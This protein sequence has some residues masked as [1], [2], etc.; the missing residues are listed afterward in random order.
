MR[1]VQ[2][3]ATG[4]PL[5]DRAVALPEPGPGEVRV[6]VAAAGICHSDAHYRRG[7]PSLG[8]LPLTLG[9]EVA[10]TVDAVGEGVAEGAWD[11]VD[12]G[13]AEVAPNP[14]IEVVSSDTNRALA[15]ALVPGERVCLHYLVTCGRCAACLRGG[16]QFC[17]RVQMIGKDRD[18]G[19]AEYIVVP[20]RN[21]IRVPDAV[22]HA[23]AAVMMCSS[24]TA[25]HALVKGRLQPGE[26][27]AVFGIGGL[28]VSAVQLADVFG[29]ATVYAVD[30]VPAKLALAER[31]G[32]VPVS[33]AEGD[34]PLAALAALTGGRG[35]DVALDLVG[36]P[37]TIAAAVKCLG[38]QGRAVLVGIGDR[39]FTVDPYRDIL[40][41]ETE[42]IGCS[43]HMHGEIAGLL[44]L[45]ASGRLDLGAAVTR[46][47]PLAA[48]AVNAALDALEAGTDGVRTVV[49]V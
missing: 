26:S 37:A 1:A 12:E 46:E 9:H 23:H 10:G 24:A 36:R 28:G 41:K 20:A 31:L 49:R 16:E 15:R 3:V 43:D 33:A 17:A 34:D 32:A 35:V 11:A 22:S 38:V 5:E 19:F 6:R 29:A 42:I 21:A 14:P 45:A 39:P 4:R 48:G 13:V 25:W 7:G 8:S 2:L 44:E 47:V 27:V 18:G 30:R 40:G